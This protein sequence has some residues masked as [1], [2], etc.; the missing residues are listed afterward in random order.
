[1]YGVLRGKLVSL[2]QMLQIKRNA[3][4]KIAITMLFGQTRSVLLVRE[5]PTQIALFSNF[6]IWDNVL[7]FLSISGT[8][9]LQLAQAV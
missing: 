2:A 6:H 8:A 3:W 7:A 1:M 5:S 9:K 4:I